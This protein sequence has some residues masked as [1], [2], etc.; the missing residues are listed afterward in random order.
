MLQSLKTVL[1]GSEQDYAELVQE[2]EGASKMQIVVDRVESFTDSDRIIHNLREG[3]VVFAKI[4]EFRNT[5]IDELRRTVSKI[6]TICRALD[7][8][9]AAVANEWLI[10][11]PPAA[12]IAK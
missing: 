1:G 10:V 6:K 7:G 3:K 2:E 5:N 8:D 9:I 11:T 12:A 4:G